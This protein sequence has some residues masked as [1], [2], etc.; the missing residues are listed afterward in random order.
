MKNTSKQEETLEKIEQ[1]LDMIANIFA[2]SFLLGL[3][4]LVV[5]VFILVLR[6]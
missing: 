5:A 6:A 4:G 2:V 3:G 1:H